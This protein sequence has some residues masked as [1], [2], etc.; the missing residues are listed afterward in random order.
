M[1]TDLL[2]IPE[3]RWTLLPELVEFFITS[4][5]GG[6]K[7]ELERFIKAFAGMQFVCP[8]THVLSDIARDEEIVAALNRDD[9][10]ESR[11]NLLRQHNISYAYM[12]NIW[13]I[14]E[15]SELGSPP[16][17]GRKD[18]IDQAGHWT[19][20]YSA[21][22]TDIAKMFNLTPHERSQVVLSS[23]QKKKKK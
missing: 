4:P 11:I 9:S 19:R 22:A 3:R 14:C 23:R 17:N 6:G 2:Q 20:K 12:Q 13:S 21:Q 8:G 18:A 7:S 1:N 10:V 15:A 5:E 16:H